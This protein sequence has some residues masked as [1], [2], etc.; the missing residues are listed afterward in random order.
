MGFYNGSINDIS[1]ITTLMNDVESGSGIA[2]TQFYS[3]LTWIGYPLLAPDR[4]TFEIETDVRIKIRV[5]KEYK[6]FVA[7]NKNAGKPMYSWSTDDIMTQTDDRDRLADALEKIRVVP[8]P[9]YAYSEYERDRLDNR[10]KI[11]N[12]PE[13]C[14][15]QI[16]S[17]NGKLVKTFK[18]SSPITFQDWQL[19]NEAEVPVASGIYLIRVHIPDVGDKILKLFLGARQVDLQGL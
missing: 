10:V 12:L 7:T 3:S 2:K 15:V 18:K 19:K 9:Y 1:E 8:N 14:T 13:V 5:N 16:Y 17:T 11:T 4:N 6:T